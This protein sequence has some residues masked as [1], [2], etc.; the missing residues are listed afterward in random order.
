MSQYI[1]RKN[2]Y[3][4]FLIIN[5]AMAIIRLSIFSEQTIF[6]HVFV[7]IA[8]FSFFVLGWE[9][10]LWMHAY[11]E[12][13]FP[14]N[15]KPVQRITIQVFLTT[16]AFFIFS[17]LLFTG[18]FKVF[19]Q[20]IN[21]T[22]Q[23]V[24]YL[25][26]FLIALI[27]NL[28]LFGTHYFFQWKSDLIS[29]TILEKEQAIVKYDALRNQLNPHFLF[30]ALTSLNSLIFANQQL[31]SDFLQQL[32]KVYRYILQNKE[33]ETVSLHTE[34]H[35]VQHYIFLLKT[36]FEEGIR[37]R[38]NVKEEDMDKGIVPV[39]SQSLIENAVKHNIIS[40]D[41]PLVITISSDGVYFIVENNVIRK[42]QVETSNKLGMENMQTLYQYL[43]D[44]PIEIESTDERYT[45]RIPLI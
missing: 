3:L 42:T 19:D 24:I 9:V 6:F 15:E 21:S 26:N 25:L 34:L 41:Q 40:K 44:K 31:A 16:V 27:F 37:I 11:F 14:I 43:S 30:N 32:S 22:V 13:I 5:I 4:V 36:R 8:S 12:K 23:N 1:S 2:S 18:A 17:E 33:R 10:L 45:V 38:M 20:G 28:T 7:F 35:F 29:K 39:L